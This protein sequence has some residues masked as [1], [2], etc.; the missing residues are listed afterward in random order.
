M[1][2]LTDEQ[3]RIGRERF[4]AGAP[5]IKE[6]IDALTEAEADAMF[7]TLDHL[8]EVETM[9]A[10]ERYARARGMD[11]VEFFFSCVAETAM[12]WKSMVDEHKKA[13]QAAIGL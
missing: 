8:R 13:I 1:T 12:E 7:T 11:S 6:K 3:K 4:L 10:L 9:N 5:E 2:K